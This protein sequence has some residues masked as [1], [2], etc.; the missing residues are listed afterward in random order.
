M[1][2]RLTF[3]RTN[4]AMMLRLFVMGTEFGQKPSS[5]IL[6]PHVLADRRSRGS[7]STITDAFFALDFDAAVQRLGMLH[8]AKHS[9]R[10]L[11][12]S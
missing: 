2:P 4:H 5:W 6:T 9:P 3:V 12:G 7:G 11:L 8:Y 1:T 10:G